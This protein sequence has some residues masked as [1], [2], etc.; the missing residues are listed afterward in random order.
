[1]SSDST[2]FPFHESMDHRHH[3]NLADIINSYDGKV[4]LVGI[5]TLLVVI[6]F[7]LLLHAYAK[8]VISQ[9]RERRRERVVTISH[10]LDPTLLHHHNTTTQFYNDNRTAGFLKDGLDI[11]TIASLPLFVYKSDDVINANGPVLDECAICLSTFEE[12]EVGRLLPV[13]QHSF[14]VECIDMWLRS[15]SSC[16]ICRSPVK[17]EKSTLETHSP[18]SHEI[19]VSQEPSSIDTIANE[20]SSHIDEVANG[21][22][23][24]PHEVLVEIQMPSPPL[25]PLPPP[26]PPHSVRKSFKRMLSVKFDR[27]DQQ[28]VFPSSSSS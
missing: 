22:P 21:N 7:V 10:I 6:S 15:H 25:P 24:T 28:K 11:S 12:H 5:M 26:S 8:W 27:L 4:I 1:M 17:P 18:S 19:S 9:A 16:P 14:H 13:C 23:P 20:L 3:G 2:P